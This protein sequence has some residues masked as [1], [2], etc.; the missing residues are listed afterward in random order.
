M[1]SAN[2]HVAPSPVP[3]ADRP[4]ITGQGDRFWEDLQ[5]GAQLRGP[6][7]TITDSH[8]VQG[9]GLTGD[10]TMASFRQ[11]MV[12]VRSQGGQSAWK[13]KALNAYLA[14]LGGLMQAERVLAPGVLNP[15]V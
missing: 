3:F 8:L 7:I 6:G 10:W 11:E 15:D 5:V 9:A 1:S 13:N 2:G 14:G 12:R 4:V